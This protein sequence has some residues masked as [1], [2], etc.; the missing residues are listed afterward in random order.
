MNKPFTLQVIETK[1]NII[2]EIE[3][4]QLPVYALKIILTELYNELESIEKEE[5]NRYNEDNKKN[6]KKVS[7][8]NAKN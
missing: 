6:K 7:D 3:N 8:E 5:I 1:N 2:K 4:S